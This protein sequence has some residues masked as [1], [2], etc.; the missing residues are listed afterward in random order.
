MS[1]LLGIVGIALML[2]AAWMVVQRLSASAR[3]TGRV[4]DHEA[5]SL[6]ATDS[7]S[8]A[9]TL[10]HPVVAFTDRDGRRH[11]FTAVGGDPDR[12]PPRGTGV[13]VRYPPGSPEHAYVA[14]C[15]NTWAMPL[16]WAA[17]GA[18]AAFVAWA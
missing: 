14:G 13:A 16:A 18:R 11:R 7:T 9:T 3:A 2:N 17:A 5:R 6:A 8:P 1:W 12:R 10:Y 15:A 4:V